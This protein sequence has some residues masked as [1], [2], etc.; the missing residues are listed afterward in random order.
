[1]A[2]EPGPGDAAHDQAGMT[3]PRLLL[4]ASPDDFL[5]E[6]E[7][8][9]FEAA[10]HEAYPQGE[11]STFEE[12]PPPGRLVQELASPSLFSP[13]RLIVVSDASPYISG[14]DKDNEA[15]ASSLGSLP[16]GDVTLLLA[17][18]VGSSPG[19]AVAEAAGRRGELRFLALPEAPKPWDEARVSRPQRR[20]L[21]N[22]VARVAPDLAT[23]EEVV[24][25]LCEVYGF[26]PR[27]LAQAATRLALAGGASEAAVRAQAGAGECSIREI[28]EAL[29]GRDAARFARF[30]GT[31]TAGGTLTDWRG[32]AVAPE[33]FG[34]TLAGAVGRLLRQALAV[35]GHAARAGLGAELQPKRCAARDWYPKTFKPGLFPRL[36]EDIEATPASPLAGMSPWQLHRAFRLA[37]RYTEEELIEALGRSAG[38]A[39]EA[40]RG[41]EVLAAVSELVLGVL[42]PRAG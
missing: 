40:G 4:L 3:L 31:L 17:A 36:E 27:E 5:L 33:R 7:R 19:G 21:A 28:E 23:N 26:R 11:A 2:K 14:R 39:A 15:L 42:T 35:R 29:L 16:L 37:A 9:D 12:A 6:L 32:E 38:S 30:V 10:W 34:R 41:P 18:V 24:D 20:L 1:M 13:E 22:V 8:H 25:A